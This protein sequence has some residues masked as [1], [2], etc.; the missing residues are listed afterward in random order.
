MIGS[1]SQPEDLKSSSDAGF[2]AQPAQA[3]Q[4]SSRPKVSGMST[5]AL[6]S[7]VSEHLEAMED[8][9]MAEVI[10]DLIRRQKNTLIWYKKKADGKA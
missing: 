8:R 5:K 4:M 6:Y 10:A 9:W 7:V 1:D 2:A 3:E